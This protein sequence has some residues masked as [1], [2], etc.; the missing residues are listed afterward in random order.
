M[1][2][3]SVEEEKRI[4]AETARQKSLRQMK[5]FIWVVSAEIRATKRLE[6]SYLSE[7]RHKRNLAHIDDK[8]RIN[9]AAAKRRS[10]IEK[11]ERRRAHMECHRK[12]SMRVVARSYMIAYGLLRGKTLIEM[13]GVKTPSNPGKKIQWG[14]VE[15]A[16]NQHGPSGFVPKFGQVITHPDEEAHIPRDMPSNDAIE[17]LAK[18]RAA[19]M[20]LN[21]LAQGA[22]PRTLQ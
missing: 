20:V 22:A 10:S 3:P 12:Y 8:L 5:D 16:I 6:H 19:A 4:R 9:S 2:N 15:M 13:E 18:E 21:N 11:L 1:P 14:L 17:I 7:L